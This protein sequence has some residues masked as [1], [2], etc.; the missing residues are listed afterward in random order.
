[1]NCG[2]IGPL[3]SAYYDGEA[4]AEERKFVED[5]LA[6]SPEAMAQLRAYRRITGEFEA[7]PRP[8]PPAD[9]R[10]NV[11]NQVHRISSAN[12]ARYSGAAASPRYR[13]TERTETGSVRQPLT[14]ASVLSQG[15]KLGAL[16]V[17]LVALL[18]GLI[19]VFNQFNKSQP[20]VAGLAATQTI[21]ALQSASATP[22]PFNPLALATPT[23][24]TIQANP[25]VTPA[26]PTEMPNNPPNNGTSVAVLPPPTDTAAPPRPINT[27]APTRPTIITAPVHPTNTTAPAPKPSNTPLAATPP[28]ATA[29]PER[30]TSTPAPPTATLAS[31]TAT[32]RPT[33]TPALSPTPACA[34][35]PVR[36]F[37]KLYNLYPEVRAEVGCAIDT[38]QAVTGT[39][40]AFQYGTMIWDSKHSLIYV[41]YD[42]RHGQTFEVYPENWDESQGEPTPVVQP[43]SGYYT[44]IRGFGKVWFNHNMWGTL[45]FA[46]QRYETPLNVAVE[47]FEHGRMLW[48]DQKLI[49]VM[50]GTPT[51]GNDPNGLQ[52]SGTWKKYPD[53]FVDGENATPPTPVPPNKK[54]MNND[55]PPN[56]HWAGQQQGQ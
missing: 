34:V 42:N 53:T 5:C 9:L 6:S 1:M 19:L 39:L 51:P 31:P 27:P 7:L 12:A 16:L 10:R 36:G 41:F 22:T 50:V 47:G 15:L 4:T 54:V 3:L 24:S 33:S 8:T 56:V 30:P 35:T 45:G 11:L 38:E 25:S 48:T 17:A 2:E 43:P 37:G 21:I 52:F 40:L 44:P 14:V 20:G 46:K 26:P 28:S 55:Q 29:T 23:A 49:Y 32:A 13:T 18:V